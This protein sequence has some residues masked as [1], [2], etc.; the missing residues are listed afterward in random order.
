MDKGQLD[1]VLRH[2]RRQLQTAAGAALTDAQLLERFV[3]GRD[4]GA[5]ATLVQ[6]HA[7]MVMG[8][9]RRE[10]HDV[11]DAEDVFQAAFFILAKRARA[12]RRQDAVGGWLYKVV[13]NL[14]LKARADKARRQLL[15][16]QGGC[17][18]L[19]TLDKD[20]NHDEMRT[21]LDQELSRL[22]EKYRSPVVLHYLEGKSKR[23]TAGQLGWSEGTVSGRLARARTLLRRRLV[24]R[25][26]VLSSASLMSILT[27]NAATATIL[28]SLMRA[29]IDGALV[30]AGNITARHAI[31]ASAAGLAN[32][33]VWRML[34]AKLALVAAAT[35]AISVVGFG[36]G[37][38]ARNALIEK[39]PLVAASADVPKSLP[40][41]WPVFHGNTLQT[42]VAAAA[43]PDPLQICWKFKA[44]DS[45]ES[46]AAI[47]G[48]V[49]YIGSLDEFLYALDL[50][51]GEQKW[52]YK[53]GSIKA[54]PSVAD[55]AVYVGNV[56]GMFH[57]VD[58][59]TGQKRWT[60]EAGA[61][62]TSGANFTRDA[63]LFGS[64]D[65]MVYCLSK[66]GKE[67]WK[68]RVPGGPV[69]GSPAVIGERTFAAG[70][71]SNLHVIDTA[72]GTEIG[73]SLDLG[74]QVGATVAV[75]GDRLFVG[76]MSS[77]VLGIDWKKGEILW[78]FEPAQ[79][80][81]PFFASPALTDKLV[82]VGSR[83][84]RI[85]ALDRKTGKEIWNF[86]TRNKVDGSPVVAGKRVYV[87]SSDKF[88]YVLDLATGTESAHFDLGSPIVAT[89][90]VAGGYL[91]IGTEDGQ[92]FCFGTKNTNPKR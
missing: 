1:A 17:M 7:V 72:K 6:R 34:M 89:P 74:G 2:L 44:K 77:Q 28:P 69:M 8:V 83:D 90:A 60:Y 11:H 65:E 80:Q 58:A 36:A 54:A 33:M 25:G 68:F 19:A 31:S 38:I 26:F 5:F 55:G 23:E 24:R 35:L 88:L 62:I 73:D 42:G 21:L 86:P 59:A 29:T 51:T 57:C 50:R 63:V 30:F 18:A 71:D 3:R 79:P 43:L 16:R 13:Y 9:A 66:A 10:L 84:K 20:F 87:G 64:G 75:D 41:G 32:A 61:E 49:V 67:L 27:E 47:S 22:P 39:T 45:V 56:D 48:G 81:Q 15:E 53:A 82:I 12:I 92:V 14:A 37:A 70:C 4:E 78:K 85:H 40:E 91:V 52:S 46:S 76:T